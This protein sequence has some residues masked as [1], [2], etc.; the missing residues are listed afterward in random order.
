MPD[1]YKFKIPIHI[2][3]LDFIGSILAGLGLAEWFANT[4]FIP[5]YFQFNHYEIIMVIIGVMLVLPAPYYILTKKVGKQPRE[6]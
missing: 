3:I 5:S 6:I 2:H 1:N 4:N